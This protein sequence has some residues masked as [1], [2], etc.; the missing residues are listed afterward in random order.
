ME[1]LL[2]HLKKLVIGELVVCLSLAA[3]SPL[4]GFFTFTI[5]VSAIFELVFAFAFVSSFL[6]MYYLYHY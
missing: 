3:L 2:L 1:L 6:L 5:Q 4:I